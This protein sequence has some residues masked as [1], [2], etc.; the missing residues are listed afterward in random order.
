MAATA[1]GAVAPGRAARLGLWA[2]GLRGRRLPFVAAAFGT[3]VG[4]YFALPAEPSAAAGA[5]LAAL[6][7]GL[8]ALAWAGRGGA[9]VLA[10]PVAAMVGGMVAAQARTGMVAAPVLPWRYYGPVE[11]RVVAVDRSASG[12]P[13]VT[14]DRVRLDGVAAVPARVRVSLH[15]AGGVAPAPGLRV[16]TTAHLQPPPG[17]VEPG[18]FDFQRHAWFGRLG[19][20]GYARAPLLLAEAEAEGA[21]VA[22]LR[23]AVAE[24][25]RARMPGPAGEVAAA[26]TTG[27]RAGLP[28]AVV[29]RLR[30]A[31]LAHLLAIS[32]LHMGLLVGCVFWTVR[33]GLALWPRVA[34]T[35]P[36]RAWAAAAAL[37]VAAAYLALSGGG[38]ATQ[39][40]FVMAAVMLG[41]ILLGRRALSIRSV[42]LAA[43]V[44]LALRPEALVGPGFQ[45]SFAATGALVLAFGWLARR[46]PRWRRGLVGAG[47]ALLLSSAVAGLATAPVAAA[48]FNR[49]SGYGLV[50]NLLAVPAMGTLVMPS[51]LAGAVLA[52]LGLEAP[53][54]WLAARGIEWILA[55]AAWA[56][57]AP[58]ADIRVVA[59]P[60]AVLPLIGLGYALV[61]AAWG[62][63]R[64]AGLV[65]LAV[66]AALWAGAE[67]PAL[68]VSDDGRLA[69]WMGP[70]GRS[71][72]RERGAGFVAGAWLEN[73]GDAATQAEAA[74]RPGPPWLLAATGARRTAAALDAC[75][76]GTVPAGAILVTDEAV[77]G[78]AGACAVI[79][80]AR[81]RRTGAVAVM[82][83]PEGPEL[84]GARAAQGDRPWVPCGR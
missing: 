41:A 33:G 79:D 68:L 19:A 16:M 58:G 52:P 73:D 40:A 49:A 59:P 64:A 10:L 75:R 39:R 22:R 62:R 29:E 82:R 44:V 80:A 27:D 21:P 66:A 54:L 57:A 47:V 14:L 28:E 35:R 31:N 13:R 77:E 1:D 70:E 43:L 56:A 7:A 83:G 53:A 51:L 3:G 67:R 5:A 8:L 76:A 23:H 72:T 20:L 6:A 81:L 18:A 25:L 32:G 9:W 38:I 46:D 55:V 48:H 60:A 65:P 50:A 78:P 69:G 4:A 30:V 45:M 71:L 24:G 84:R 63:W 36:T 15:G 11:G 2:Q 42:A 17:P 74:A 12:A 37:P 61:G 34:L 26:I